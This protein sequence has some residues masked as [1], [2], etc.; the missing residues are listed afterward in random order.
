MRTDASGRARVGFI[1]PDNLTT[2]QVE[3][4]GI[5]QDTS[6]GV[7]YKEFQAR[8]QVMV[9][10]LQPRFV[11]PGDAFSIGTKVFN[12]TDTKQKLAVGFESHTLDLSSGKAQE[13]ITLNA[14]ESATVFFRV[15]APEALQ[16]GSHAY[17]V[18]A[19]NDQYEDAVDQSVK[20]RRNDTYETVATAG[21]SPEQVINEYVFVPQSVV[22]DKGDLTVKHSATLAVFLS[23][24]LNSLLA[25][26]HGCSEQVASKLDAMATLKRGLNLKNIGDTFT[27]DEVQFEGV[28]YS[29]D[30]LVEVGLARLY[31]NQKESGGFS[32]YPNTNVSAYATLHIANTLKNL[33]EAGYDVNQDALNRAFNYVN[34]NVRRDEFKSHDFAIV[35]AYTAYRIGNPNNVHAFYRTRINQI[36]GD[37]ALLAENM[38]T[39]TLTHL[40]LLLSDQEKIFGGRNK[41]KVYKLLE[42]K[43]DI[44]ARGAFLPVNRN[45]II[46]DYYETPVKNTAFLLKAFVADERNNEVLDR[47]LR[48]LLASRAKDGAWGSTNNT[49]SVIDAMTDYFVWLRENESQYELAVSLDGKELSNFSYGPQ[50]IL[51]QNQSSVPVADLKKDELHSVRLAKSNQNNRVNNV[52]YDVSLKYFL[53]IEQIPPRDEGFT[54]TRALYRLEDTEGEQPVTRAA[55]GEVLRGQLKIIVPQGRTLV[56]VDDYIPAGVSLINFNL[57]TE[58]ASLREQYGSGGAED[59][60]YQYD[61]KESRRLRPDLEELRDDR[62]FLYVESLPAGEYTYEYFVRAAVPGEFHHLPAVVSEWYFPENFGRTSGGMFT[63]AEE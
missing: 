56:A 15:A 40:A 19:K 44:D 23:D 5:T 14:G 36:L 16:L 58:D 38:S 25:F 11:V 33:Q 35:S 30:Q 4:V 9:Q 27:L 1:L 41:E 60:W 22:P 29:I 26:P 24:A 31:E 8:K 7:G 48:W 37:Q 46:W 34:D 10:P 63:V 43:I 55:V 39:M 47:I 32:Y 6:L 20:I 45:R 3:S 51:T 52:Y 21:A 53:P 62:L 54:V 50:T 61:P 12:Q 28:D 59:Y 49:I 42:N 13:A 2:W 57:A 18:S 17:T